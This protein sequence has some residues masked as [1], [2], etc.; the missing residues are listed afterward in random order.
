MGNL[1]KFGTN[2]GGWIFPQEMSLDKGSIIY[3]AGVG[4]DISFDLLLHY[5][6]GCKVL[7]IDPTPRAF[8]HVQWVKKY[9]KNKNLS[10]PPGLHGDY[11]TLLKSCG[12]TSFEFDYLDLALSDAKEEAKFYKPLNPAHVS[13]TLVPK[14]YGSDSLTVQADHLVNVMKTR[15]DSKIDLLKLDIEGGEVAVLHHMLDNG[16]FPRY[17]GVEFDLLAKGKDPANKSQK[18]TDRLQQNYHVLHQDG[19]NITFERK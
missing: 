12:L 11:K 18:L 19:A 9:F 8:Q 14:M 7:L 10:M 15:G 17:L 6:F 4:E 5:H 13:H 2:Y 3:S 16:V 1:K